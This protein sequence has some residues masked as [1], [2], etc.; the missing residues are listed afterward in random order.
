MWI[1]ITSCIACLINSCKACHQLNALHSE[2]SQYFA[3]SEKTENLSKTTSPNSWVLAI[4]PFSLGK[5]SL[6][7]K[8]Y[9]NNSKTAIRK[10]KEHAVTR[11]G[12]ALIKSILNDLIEAAYS[13]V[14]RDHKE[15]LLN[16]ANAAL[17]NSSQYLVDSEAMILLTYHIKSVDTLTMKELIEET[18]IIEPTV[19]FA[20]KRLINKTQLVTNKMDSGRYG[21]VLTEAGKE[22]LNNI[23]SNIDTL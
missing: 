21:Y 1:G 8:G 19:S 13:E 16:I 22:K 18:S 14:T 2:S 11:E 15:E 20:V 10:K 4:L 23:I 5:Q 9:L 17:I 12:N 3:F 6:I 7:K